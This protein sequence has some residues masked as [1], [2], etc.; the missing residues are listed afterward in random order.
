ML[1]AERVGLEGSW[2]DDANGYA[3]QQE[4]EEIARQVFQEQ[5]ETWRE[6]DLALPLESPN[7]QRLWALVQAKT[8][9]RPKKVEKWSG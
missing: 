9:V 3:G 6:V 5:A 8:Q 2:P 7:G 4:V 1:P